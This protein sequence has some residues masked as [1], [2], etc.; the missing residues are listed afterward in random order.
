MATLTPAPAADKRSYE[1]VNGLCPRVT[2]IGADGLAQQTAGLEAGLDDGLGVA[3]TTARHLTGGET[4]ARG[5]R[6]AVL[7]I[8][9]QRDFH[10][11]GSLAVP[12]ADEDCARTARFLADHGGA[13]DAVCVTLDSHGVTHVAHPSFWEKAG[14]VNA[15]PLPFTELTHAALARGEWRARDPEMR[16]W[17]VEYARRLEAGG[18]FTLVVWPEHCLMGTEG[19]AVVPPIRD[20]VLAWSRTA[21]RPAA[22]LSKGMNDRTEMYSCFKAEVALDDD[23]GTRRNDALVRAL[24]GF[25]TVV[26]CGQAKSHCVNYS[27]RDLVAAW[28]PH[29]KTSDIVLLNDAT[30][31]VISFEAA[32]DA[33]EADMRAAGVTIATTASFAP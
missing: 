12:G 32:A 2:P 28:P 26:V 8:D 4:L 25:D 14:D 13:I 19:H 15:R 27:V 5:G 21:G 23:P 33:F 31:P 6:V 20:A 30:S 17:A 10:G 7:I 18:R 24:A 9:P 22:W 29:R 11:G 16:A 1:E 3:R